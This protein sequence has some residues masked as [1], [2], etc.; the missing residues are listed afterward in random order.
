[1]QRFNITVNLAANI[2]NNL[3]K[4]GQG[5]INF[6]TQLCPDQIV[7]NV[8]GGC[9]QQFRFQSVNFRGRQSI[10]NNAPG[11]CVDYSKVP[12][13]S[14]IVLILESPHCCEYDQN[15]DPI[16]P[17]NDFNSGGAG[18]NILKY[19]NDVFLQSPLF[20]NTLH[21]NSY[22]LVLVNAVQ[23]QASQGQSPIDVNARDENWIN[24]WSAGFQD[25]LSNRLNAL[26]HSSKEC[27][28]VNLCTFG[29]KGL[30]FMV[31][32]ELRKSGIDFFEGYHPSYHWMYPYK[33]IFY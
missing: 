25:D 14:Y 32:E 29:R 10:S 11:Y 16:G 9:G 23:Y 15:G 6:S 18:N 3:T 13:G 22:K 4:P 8:I 33:R 12:S 31:N 2:P 17:A 5:A 30:H 19:L 20:I 26:I 24:F 21:Q 28:I 27:H 7:G 1:M